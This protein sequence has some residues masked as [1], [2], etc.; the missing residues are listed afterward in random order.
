[1]KEFLPRLLEINHLNPKIPPRRIF[2]SKPSSS[3]EALKIPKRLCLR[4]LNIKRAGRDFSFASRTA[5]S[6]A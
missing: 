6:L 1:M 3:P 2:N 4:I 5:A